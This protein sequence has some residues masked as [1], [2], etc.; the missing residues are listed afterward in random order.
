[1]SQVATT[2]IG[3]APPALTRNRDFLKLWTG[4]TI[5]V[6]GTQVTQLALPLVAATTL[7]VTPFEFGV[8]GMVDFLP[9]II[10]SLPAGVW[11]DRL[12]RRP[13]LIIGDVGRALSMATIPISFALGT[14]TIW[15]L[16]VVGFINGC[17]TVF[18][19][20][21]YQS[22]LPSLVERD[23]LIDGN[24]KLETTRSAASVVGP[25]VAGTLIG[26]IG[27]PV[28]IG[29]DAI[30]YAI[31]TAFL[32]VIRRR[33]PMPERAVTAEGSRTSVRAEAVE[34][35]RY[36]LGHAYLRAIAA[37]SGLSNLFNNIAMSIY[38][39]FLVRELGFTPG[40]L[41]LVFSIASVGFLIG[42][43]TARRISD[44]LGVGP[45]MICSAALFGPP[46][47]VLPFV[48]G[49][50]AL[51]VVSAAG[52]VAFGA[53]TVW[54]INQ[55]SLRQAITPAGMQ[56]RMNATMRFISWGTIPF[57]MILGGF[58]GALIGLRQTVLLGA[59]L[60][61]LPFLP[62]LLSPIRSIRAMPEPAAEA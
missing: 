46:L 42:A 53:A 7:N 18:F 10:L 5:S 59:V 43:L 34:G 4:Q 62:V 33:E 32:L 12:P 45:T 50:L 40:M 2:P 13:I 3:A 20:V 47:L 44:R 25:G 22:Y 35:L 36:V 61:L 8:L 27:A 41:G 14:L 52:F 21:A 24:S 58:L 23:Q 60:S 37:C 17:L 19:D 29:I 11:V 16:Y 30:S 51:P 56:G 54:N 28:A 57:G 31:S 1:M 38:I 48:G 55:V 39:L 26:F 49:P 15:Q 9:F 6:A